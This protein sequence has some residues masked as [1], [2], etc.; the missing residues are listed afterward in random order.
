MLFKI[1]LFKLTTKDV[2]IVFNSEHIAILFNNKFKFHGYQNLFKKVNAFGLIDR[3]TN[4][5]KTKNLVHKAHLNKHIEILF[6]FQ[7]F[8]FGKMILSSGYVITPEKSPIF[9][10]S[11]YF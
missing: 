8:N 3:R 7:S 5:K 10:V 6:S 9:F 4:E 11:F 2:Q 1:K